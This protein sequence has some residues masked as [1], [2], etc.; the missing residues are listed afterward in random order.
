[1]AIPQSFREKY[2]LTGDVYEKK[3]V[4][5]ALSD[6]FGA[7]TRLY[8]DNAE[9]R[10]QLE[11][12]K[13]ERDALSLELRALSASGGAKDNANDSRFNEISEKISA[14]EARLTERADALEKQ[15]TALAEALSGAVSLAVSTVMT[16]ILVRCA[17]AHIEAVTT[18]LSRLSELCLAMLPILGTVLAM[19]GSGGAAVATHGGFLVLLG[20]LEAI[21]GEAFGGIVGISLALSAANVFSS[22]FRLGAVARAIRRCFGVFFGAIMSLLSFI[23]SIKIGIAAAGDSVAMRGAKMFASNAIPLV[24]SAIGDSFKTLATALTYMKSVS[25]AVGI[26]LILLLALPTF[27]SVWLYRCGLVL[28]SGA[29]E[30]LGCDR[31]REL[32][33]GVVSVYGYMLAVI[34]IS[35]VVFILMLTLFTKS[36]LAFGGGL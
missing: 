12:I 9:L 32:L 20:A 23:L 25:G 26:I 4:E 28:V 14:L 8:A 7:S 31:E 5:A 1:M 3:S 21:V 19:G 27:L 24:G 13:A 36:T 29:A 34:A 2:S 35:A 6:L 16:A 30:M 11:S 17:A 15:I 10:R 22:K 18:F 33:S